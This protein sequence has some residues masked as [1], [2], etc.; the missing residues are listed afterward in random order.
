MVELYRTPNRLYVNV[1]QD[2]EA[3]SPGA[4]N[5]TVS[6]VVEALGGNKKAVMFDADAKSYFVTE[7]FRAKNP[8]IDAPKA[9]KAFTTAAAEKAIAPD[10]E[11]L[12]ARP[13]AE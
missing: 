10:V 13:Q 2:T 7:E 1:I 6:K 4:E 12:R 11:R 8:D 3:K 5:F 9:V